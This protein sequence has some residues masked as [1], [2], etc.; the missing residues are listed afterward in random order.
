MSTT[1]VHLQRKNGAVVQDC[2]VY[3]GRA[4]NM[5][6]WRLPQSKWHNPYSVK[7]YGAQAIPMFEQYLRN[8]P[9]I[10]EIEELRGKRLGC[11]CSPQPCHGDVLVKILN[12][13]RLVL[14]VVKE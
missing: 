8:S 10:N 11:W 1:V 2:D 3:I 4:C 5:G 13:R 12:G 14:R 7:Q 9:L 6:G